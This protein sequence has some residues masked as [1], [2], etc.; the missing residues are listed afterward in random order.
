MERYAG[1][2]VVVVLLGVLL[3]AAFSSLGSNSN[4]T[5]SKI[6]S[7]VGDGGF[8]SPAQEPPPVKKQPPG[9]APLP[10]EVTDQNLL[11]S[12]EPQAAGMGLPIVPE[13]RKIVFTATLDVV[14][15]ELAPVVTKVEDQVTAVQGFISKSEVKADPSARR[16]ATF[17]IRVPV[18]SF[19]KLLKELKGIGVAERDQIDSEDKTDEI[20]DVQARIKN[21]KQEEEA[22]NKLLK[23]AA[24]RI[25][26]ILRL[27]EHIKTNRGEIERAEGRLN[28]L[29]RL[30][31][32]STIY[33]TLKDPV[34]EP[35]KEAKLPPEPE[36]PPT[37]GDRVDKTFGESWDLF[38]A[39]M[40]RIALVAVAAT[41][42]LPLLVPLGIVGFFSVRSSIRASR[43][44]LLKASSPSSVPA[45]PAL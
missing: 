8:Y 5:F 13:S 44:A 6:G 45:P 20:V 2:G 24:N 10:K 37:F 21:L 34:K 43:K 26:E 33:L 40:Q 28:T 29:S 42:W 36:V 4:V 19:R 31:A 12:A 9:T 38:K 27:R 16:V 23:E 14:V 35:G 41:P 18:D 30:A 25:D 3:V 1:I 11:V 7:A 22:L 15:P 17:T 39:F 32:L